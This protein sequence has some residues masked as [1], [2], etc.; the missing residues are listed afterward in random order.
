MNG[1]ASFDYADPLLP[2][3]EGAQLVV[4][5]TAKDIFPNCPRYIHRTK[6][7][8]IS[9]Y[10]PEPGHTP[11]VPAWKE[12]EVFRDYLPRTDRQGD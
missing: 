3:F 5:V 2:T 4:R 10:A 11:P 9:A 12:M 1:L 6:L 8:E 7:E